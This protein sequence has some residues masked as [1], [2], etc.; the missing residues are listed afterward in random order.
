MQESKQEIK[1]VTSI[2]T[3][4]G[5]VPN[6]SS[7]L[8][9]CQIYM[10]ISALK[11]NGSK[12]PSKHIRSYNVAATLMRD[13]VLARLDMSRDTAYPTLL[14]VRSSMTQISLRIQVG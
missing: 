2:V 4:A 7:H 9:M 8:N 5:N 14:H 12:L 3:M 1:N 10:N 11:F 6:V 13:C